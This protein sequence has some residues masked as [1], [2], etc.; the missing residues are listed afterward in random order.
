LEAI[1]SEVDISK[2]IYAL[3][4]I[5]RVKEIHNLHVSQAIGVVACQSG[6]G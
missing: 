2:M 1:P 6:S 4:K 5:P 3:G